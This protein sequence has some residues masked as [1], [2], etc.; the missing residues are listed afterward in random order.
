MM[1]DIR[2]F[3]NKFAL[4]I[5][6]VLSFMKKFIDLRADKNL[7]MIKPFMMSESTKIFVVY[8][9]YDIIAFLPK[10][11]IKPQRRLSIH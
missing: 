1:Q 5:D 3:F 11:K 2:Q 7:F 4:A 9:E 8:A 10:K 6:R